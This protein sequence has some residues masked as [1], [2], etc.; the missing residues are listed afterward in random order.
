MVI[1]YMVAVSAF[2]IPAKRIWQTMTLADGTAIEV[3]QVGDAHGHWYTDRNGKALR[4]NENGMLQYISDDELTALK[5]Q[6]SAKIHSNNLRRAARLEKFREANREQ[7]RAQKAKGKTAFAGTKKGLVILVNFSDK[8]MTYTQSDF[9]ALA[10]ETGYSKNGCI[11]SVKDYFYDQS[12]GNFTLQFDIA[13]PY[14]VSNK[15]SYYGKDSGTVGD[16]AHPAE[17]VIEA[18]KLADGDVDFSNYD[19]DDDGEVDQ[20][21]VIYAGYGQAQGGSTNTIWPHEWTLEEAKDYND[22]NGPLY[23]DG[24]KIDTYACSSELHG[25]S[26][27]KIDGIG[28]MCHEF[29]HC[30]GLPDTYDTVGSAFGMDTWDIMDY[31]NYGA[32][33]Y[34]P[35]G[36][37]SY[38]RWI[39]GWLDPIVLD[40]PCYVNDMPALVDLPQACIIY[41]DA[42]KDEYYLLEN[43]QLKSWDQVLD[44]H[45]MLVIHVDYNQQAWEDDE[46]NVYSSHQRMTIIPADNKLSAANTE[47]DT[48]PGISNNTSLTDDSTPA[49]KLF[50]ANIDGRKFMGKPITD[51]AE[52]DG[53]ISF[54]FMGGFESP[55]AT[56][57]T[58]ISSDGTAFTA[59]WNAIDDADSY[60]LEIIE[61]SSE[62]TPQILYSTD[63][64]NISASGANKDISQ[65]LPD[66]MTGS[67]VYCEEDGILKIGTSSSA[68][69]L[70]SI[71]M[72]APSTQSVTIKFN[73]KYY[74]TDKS[75]VTIV[76]GDKVTAVTLSDTFSDYVVTFDGISSA[77]NV[78]FRCAAKKRFYISGFTVYDGKYTAEELTNKSSAKPVMKASASSNIIT[79][80][81]GT[82]YAVTGLTQGLTYSYRVRANIGSNQ[83]GWSNTVKVASSTGIQTINTD[84]PYKNPRI[85]NLNG[86]FVGTDISS[87]PHGL[88]IIGTRKYLKK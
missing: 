65:S 17:M 9:D 44:G 2:S 38:E 71:T 63:F 15:M 73:A 40:E 45:G 86:Q 34:I 24:V 80:I 27:S 72:E 55:V 84:G 52:T 78:E 20:V 41:N 11:G 35:C 26:G 23:L 30:I 37:T 50:N 57:A 77:F 88:Y 43:R 87:L 13:G 85:Y 62:S 6:R 61:E 46:V 42:H 19:W 48:Y 69:Y 66:L 3:V 60:D 32:D 75:T 31:G 39:A 12:Y 14:T 47:G 1:L 51:I 79:G 82:S 53:L 25:N 67:K 16:D 29:S 76:A 58:D 10:N 36:Y 33:G 56:D 21:Y 28:A 64:Y 8:K 59:H 70:T 18:C 4:P 83:T 81:T 68:G 54:T 5:T 74:G 22:G 49:A 7:Q